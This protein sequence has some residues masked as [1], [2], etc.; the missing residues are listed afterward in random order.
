MLTTNY[1]TM[2]EEV[3][4]KALEPF[5]LLYY[6]VDGKDAGRFLHRDPDG[7]IRVIERPQHLCS[8][9]DG[10]HLIVKLDGGIPYDLHFNETV[11][12]SPMDFAI[13]AGR[14]PTALPEAVRRVLRDRSLLILGSSLKDQHVQSFIRW[15]AGTARGTKTWAV[16]S[17]WTETDER[18]WSAAGVELVNCDFK[19]FIP[20][21]HQE[22]I[23]SYSTN[24]L[25]SAP[26]R[27]RIAPA[28]DET[29]LQ[30]TELR[31]IL[32]MT[33]TATATITMISITRFL[34][35][36]DEGPVEDTLLSQVVSLF[37]EKIGS[38]APVG[39]KE[40]CA[41]F[42]ADIEKLRQSIG[43]ESSSETILLITGSATQAME[44]YN[45][46]ITK[47]LQRQG[48]E[49]QKIINMM[50]H[51]VASIAGESTSG[52]EKLREIGDQLERASAIGDLDTLKAHIGE[53]LAA[54]RKETLRQKQLT[55]T[56]IGELRQQVLQGNQ[57][58]AEALAAA[59]LD[60]ATGLPPKS[61]CLATMHSTVA[62]GKRR[63][64]VPL[65][66][67]RV[68]SVN[69]RFGHEIGDQVLR[70]LGRIV[71]ENMLPDDKV[72][73][74]SGPALVV[75][76]ESAETLEQL[77]VRIK[78]L[79]EKQFDETFDV[80]GRSVII[81]ISASWAAFRLVTTVAMAEGQI[82]TFIASQGGREL[83]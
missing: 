68:Q 48:S 1:D 72:F 77:R 35:R 66:V 27:S 4:E 5:H 73:R 21:L 80:R 50:L 81:P 12:I 58:P 78:R 67:S 56:L 60:T 22:V 31:S 23:E 25:A 43:P 7:V 9:R 46:G 62:A 2:L 82:Q 30:K 65:V 38:E 28:T 37:L 70:R 36:A 40:E 10:A 51:T 45:K 47:N 74:W 83:A 11:A 6:Q 26:S 53:S 24:A 57:G 17:G 33:S 42:Q 8:F 44:T 34:N 29:R 52:G 79:M 18:F 63:Y 13:S 32:G 61:A 15:S 3:F 16:G 76:S 75:V 64:L 71:S 41:A 20:A 19:A 54:F 69:A 49:L 55:D 39:N 14:L 59:E